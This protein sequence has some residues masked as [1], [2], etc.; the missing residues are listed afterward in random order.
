MTTLRLVQGFAFVIIIRVNYTN[1][2]FS[3][4][5][6]FSHPEGAK[7]SPMPFSGGLYGKRSSLPY[8]SGGFF[9]KRAPVPRSGGLYGKRKRNILDEERM[10]PISGG[11]YG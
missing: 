2:K 8:Y 7:R 11:F 9:G 5:S 10:V 6:Y 1:L 4:Y 3:T